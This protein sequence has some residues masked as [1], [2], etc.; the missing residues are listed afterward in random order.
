MVPTAS[1]ADGVA[2]A[3]MNLHLLGSIKTR[4][5]FFGAQVSAGK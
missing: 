4:V 1:R 5:Q 2:Y 3:V